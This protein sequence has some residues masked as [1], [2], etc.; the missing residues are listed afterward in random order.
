MKLVLAVGL[1]AE[2]V[3]HST[4][5]RE[6]IQFPVRKCLIVMGIMP[7]VTS[8]STKVEPL[9]LCVFFRSAR[10]PYNLRWLEIQLDPANSNSVISN[11][12]L[13]RT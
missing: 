2:Q 6:N 3:L 4:L 7:F 5:E 8:I 10:V 12:P 1:V 13:F 11:T 9:L